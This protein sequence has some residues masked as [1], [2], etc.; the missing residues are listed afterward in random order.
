M[1]LLDIVPSTVIAD[2]QYVGRK[3]DMEPNTDEWKIVEPGVITLP[4]T[5]ITI[6]RRQC[7]GLWFD[8]F[9]DDDLILFMGTLASAKAK[10]IE[11]IRDLTAVGIEP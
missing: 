10:A 6:R 5:R 7:S 2:E 3:P 1:R 8:L 4:G 11:L 9:H